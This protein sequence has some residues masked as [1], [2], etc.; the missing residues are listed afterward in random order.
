MSAGTVETRFRVTGMDCGACSRKVDTAV[1]R[2]TGVSEVA[3]SF[4]TEILTVS[5]DGSVGDDELVRQVEALGFGAEPDASASSKTATAAPWWRTRKARTL[6]ACAVALLAARILG[7][8]APDLGR[9]ALVLALLVGLVPIARRAVAAARL[10]TPFSI[11]ALMTVAACG[12][13]ALGAT[14]EAAA[15]VLL[16]LVGE[17]LEGVAATRARHAI[18]ALG[19]LVPGTALVEED[20]G[21]TRSVP[22][23]DLRPG[24]VVVV[25]PGDRVACD[26]VVVEGRSDVDQSPVTGESVLRA[27]AAGD[28]VFAGSVNATG[29]L[30]VR[31]TSAAADNTLARI[32][33]LVEEAQDGK[34]PTQRFIE[35]FSRAYTP[36][37]VALAA[38]VAVVPPLASGGGWDVWIYRAL[39]LLLIGCPCALVI[40]TPAAVSAALSA[41][42][43]RGLLVKGGAALERLRDLSVVAFDKTGTL[44]EGRPRVTDV[45][46][47]GEDRGRVLATA[48]ALERGSSHPLALAILE[49]ARLEG[50][51]APPAFMVEA[52]A[53]EGVAGYVAGSEAFLGSAHA[54]AAR[55]KPDAPLRAAI[56]ALGAEGKTVAVLVAGGRTV[57][58]IGLRD[59]ARPDAKRGV[60]RLSASGVR[61]LMLTGDDADAARAIGRD[62]GLEVR[63]GLMPQDK[64]A[65]VRDLQGRGEVVGKVGDGIN[66][67]PALAAADVGIAMGGGTDI[68][69]EAADAAVLGGRVGDVAD[70]VALSKATMANIRTNV[71]VALGLKAVFLVTTVV[72]VTGLWPAVLSDTGATVLVAANAMRML[73]WKPPRA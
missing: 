67:A 66:D 43:R 33:R 49:A 57:G 41:G 52:V 60:E 46:A 73:R 26:G 24:M 56:E 34:A 61:T 65:V 9:A 29:V 2:M 17:T 36:F 69:L 39:A 38:L 5:H 18:S 63:A 32:V 30:Q 48:A 12:A 19:D 23:G 42:A 16:F 53:G 13:V 14:G 8:F 55:A 6:A 4:A 37:V 31:V 51:K 54:A 40:S 47:P 7:V 25:R 59:E 50:L 1:R 64:L 58:A 27:K 35:R 71:A 10:G 20:G 70:L 45:L 11:E 68:A 28:D 72:G 22:A 44:T 15:V 21:D 3:V 62:L